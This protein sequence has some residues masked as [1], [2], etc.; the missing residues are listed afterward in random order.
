MDKPDKTA[1]EAALA[2]LTASID[3]IKEDKRK[4]QQEIDG[5][6]TDPASKAS[7]QE[8]RA[9][10]TEHKQKKTSLIEQKKSMR[11]QIEANKS[12]TDKLIKDKKDTRSNMKFQSLEEIEKEIKKLQRKQETTTMSLN[13]E[14]RLIKEMDGLL[15]SKSHV[16][17]LKS[18][19]GALDSV[20]AERKNLSEQLSLKD[21]EIDAESKEI[22]EIMTK[23][24]E[25]NDKD[26]TKRDAIKGLF[27]KRDELK[28]AMGVKLKE[29]DALRDE[30]RE[31][32][33]AWYN[34]QRALRAQRK[35]EYEK[36]KEKREEEKAA[37]LAKLEAEELKKAPYEEEQALCEYLAGY[38]ERT[39]LTGKSGDD[40]GGK[41]DSVVAV[42][43]DPF[44]GMKPVKKETEE[45]F[46]KG[47]GKKKR[48][49]SSK[50]QDAAGGPFKLSV[51]TF[52]QF[53]LLNLNPPTSVEQVAASVKELREK[54][55]W[56]KNQP[57]GS[58]PTATEIRRANEKAAAK[59]KGDEPA[60]PKKG[61]KFD[62]SKDEFVPLGEAVATTVNSSWG[63]AAPAAQEAS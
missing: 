7:L 41:K 5:K 28:A 57:R 6:M 12:Q 55:E 11:A 9:K 47:K 26:S 63:K 10:M 29:K 3:A 48:D 20:R 32:S 58:V 51:D 44:A 18:A 39:Y 8:L 45:Y 4:I 34:A 31:K 56:Y 19:D 35:M 13:E 46:G 25:I 33:N 61:G 50:K 49:R 40:A 53:G 37:Y 23:I 62:L 21:K 54:K 36:E 42:K 52:G 14:K 24:R 27:Q 15:A 60:A 43:D 38:L 59:L 30:Y 16:A 2:E 1:H 17:S 22:D